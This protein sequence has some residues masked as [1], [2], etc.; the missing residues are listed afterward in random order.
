MDCS[1][2]KLPRCVMV[3]GDSCT[4]GGLSGTITAI[5]DF[6]GQQLVYV[7]LSLPVS[8]WYPEALVTDTQPTS[9]PTPDAKAPA[10]PAAPAKPV[11]AAPGKK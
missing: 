3:V 4:V 9:T 5:V 11:A 10:A 1:P 7:Q 2:I 8:G 6:S